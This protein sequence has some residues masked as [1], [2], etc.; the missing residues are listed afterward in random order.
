[1]TLLLVAL[2]GGFGACLRYGL[3]SW[4][5]ARYGTLFPY[6]TLLVNVAGSFAMGVLIGLLARHVSEQSPAIRAFVGVGI[7][8]GFTTFSA[9]SL[10]VVTLIERGAAVDAGIYALA[11]VVFSV[12]G[13]FAGLYLTRGLTAWL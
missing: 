13:L 9:F 8:G 6:A 7:L 1:M 12:V 5:G 3:M 10:D 2:G 4:A 11:S